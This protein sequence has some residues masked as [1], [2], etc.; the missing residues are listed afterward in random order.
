[1]EGTRLELFGRDNWKRTY[2]YDQTAGGSKNGVLLGLAPP[3]L[4]PKAILEVNGESMYVSAGL[5][6]VEAAYAVY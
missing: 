4:C 2:F 3:V 5:Q 1:M 6:P